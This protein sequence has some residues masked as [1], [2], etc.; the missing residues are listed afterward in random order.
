MYQAMLGRTTAPYS[1]PVLFSSNIG[2]PAPA[3]ATC[4]PAQPMTAL[5]WS[6]SRNLYSGTSRL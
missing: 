3:A 4:C 2:V 1:S 5:V 6:S